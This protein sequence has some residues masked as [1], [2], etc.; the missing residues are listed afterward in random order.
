MSA[1]VQCFFGSERQKFEGKMKEEQMNQ[2]A[3]ILRSEPEDDIIKG[4]GGW[5]Y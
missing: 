1:I 4:A 5:H 2:F 3:E